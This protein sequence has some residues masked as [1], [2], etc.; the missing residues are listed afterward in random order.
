MNARTLA[1]SFAP[2][3]ATSFA[4][5]AHAQAPGEVTP[6]VIVSPVITIGAAPAAP[7]P[8]AAPMM[9]EEPGPVGPPAAAPAVICA[10]PRDG[11]MARR[12]ALGVS[13]GSMSLAPES[14]PERETEFSVGELA[15]RF[16]AT[17][18]LELELA[19]GGGRE[20]IGDDEEGDLLVTS[21]AL[22]AR[23]RFRPERAWNWFVMAGI[24]GAAVAHHEASEQEREEAT[25][26]LGMLGIGI[27]R[28][29]RRFALQAEAR[30]VAIGDDRRESGS[31]A[32]MGPASADVPAMPVEP[33]TVEE[34]K[35]GGT[36]T[37][38]LSYYF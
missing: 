25:K 30:A 20:R 14:A 28:R 33:S 10:S 36:F 1:F 2:L 32:V 38:G 22:N 9:V 17:R 4:S 27:E 19:V 13:F 23:F 16:R 21:A 34:T 37:I 26:P 24:G 35:A 12:W 15:L 11:V 29:F 8:A 5:P 3:F 7:P 31:A 18:R 6:Q